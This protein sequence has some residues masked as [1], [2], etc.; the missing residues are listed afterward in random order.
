MH[1]K[2]EEIAAPKPKYTRRSALAIGAIAVGA[3]AVRYFFPEYN[4]KW[5]TIEGAPALR[6]NKIKYAGSETDVYV[7]DPKVR[8]SIRTEFLK[9]QVVQQRW[10]AM[11]GREIT[12]FNC[13][14]TKDTTV[15]MEEERREIAEEYKKFVQFAM[16]YL[17]K[18][19]GKR[20]EAPAV[21]IPKTDVKDHK[22]ACIVGNIGSLYRTDLTVTDGKKSLT[23]PR[24]EMLVDEETIGEDSFGISMV[25]QESVRIEQKPTLLTISGSRYA[26]MQTPIVEGIHRIA[27][28]GSAKL[29]AVYITRES[30]PRD[31]EELSGMV[32]AIAEVEEGI[33]HAVSH[34]LTPHIAKKFGLK[35]SE[36]ER[37]EKIAMEIQ[38]PRYRLMPV[39]QTLLEQD[40]PL[41]LI[42]AYNEN[43]DGIREKLGVKIR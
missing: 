30:W 9:S 39:V 20:E 13:A 38:S 4:P 41:A 8:E 43:P 15:F 40:N 28:E 31:A 42:K 25:W 19:C 35:V 5:L 24:L 3:A 17:F 33:A 23:I 37:Q 1:N 36:T 16:E 14:A 22:F 27:K 11:G 21:T 32:N 12:D 18:S 29:V 34:V 7:L 2:R 26:R 10:R 6:R